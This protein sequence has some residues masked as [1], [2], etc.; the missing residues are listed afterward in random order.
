M[1]IRGAR[2][3][4]REGGRGKVAWNETRARKESWL[5]SSKKTLPPKVPDAERKLRRCGA[6]AAAV[7]AAILDSR[8]RE[9]G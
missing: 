6:A 3:G 1:H 9:E 4:G 2:E 5:P 7:A 8:E